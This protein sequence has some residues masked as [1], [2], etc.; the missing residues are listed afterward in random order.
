MEPDPF[1]PNR[2]AVPSGGA[3]LG[4]VALAVE[5]AGLCWGGT[6]GV[7]VLAAPDGRRLVV[8]L[9]HA[10]A[11]ALTRQLRQA[12]VRHRLAEGHAQPLLPARSSIRAVGLATG[13]DGAPVG[14]LA[15]G[16]PGMV[17]E[18]ACSPGAAAFWAVLLDLPVWVTDEDLSRWAAVS[19]APPGHGADEPLVASIRQLLADIDA[20]DRL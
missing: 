14:L 17:R 10:D 11:L 5:L 12:R 4:A 13:N 8:Q 1:P 2:P 9:T 7:L 3:T 6:S 15:V 20:L 18:L 16:R 19:A